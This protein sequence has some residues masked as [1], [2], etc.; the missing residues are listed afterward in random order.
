[1]VSEVLLETRGLN[2]Y[3]G[4]LQAVKDVS[5]ETR[6]G[7]IKAVIGPNGAGKTTL[8]NLISGN[9]K[10]Q[11]GSV[12]YRG[13]DITRLKPYMIARRGIFRT[14]QTSR[15]FAHMTVL[16]N[17]MVGRHTRSRAGFVSCMLNL[18]WTWKEEKAIRQRAEETLQ[19]LGLTEYKD[20][21]AGSLPFGKQRLVEFARALATEPELLLLDEP[22]AGLNVHETAE[23]SELLLKIRD[24]GVTLL[25]VEHDMSLVM[26]IS[27]QVLVLD[28]GAALAEGKPEEVQRNQQVISIYLGEEEKG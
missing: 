10:P 19:T 5:F 28:Q 8:F 21:D 17:V 2:R 26:D 4:G 1:V 12:H 7:Q 18:P 9:L 23:L 20:E 6:K 25:V 15:L 14:F 13:E 3:F 24:W 11:S 27:D 16:E 22:A